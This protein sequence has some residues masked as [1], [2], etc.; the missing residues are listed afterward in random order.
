MIVVLFFC[1]VLWCCG[2]V[3][4]WIVVCICGWIVMCLYSWCCDMFV[5]YLLL[6]GILDGVFFVVVVFFGIVMGLLM[7]LFGS[8]GGMLMGL[9]L[10]VVWVSWLLLDW[11]SD[12]EFMWW[13]VRCVGLLNWCCWFVWCVCLMGCVV[14]GWGFCWWLVV[15]LGWGC[16]VVL[17]VVLVVWWC[18]WF[19]VLCCVCWVCGSWW[20]L[21]VCVGRW[22]VWVLWCV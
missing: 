21:V 1:V 22:L 4:C 15:W 12:C 6:I 9:F 13:C 20:F 5:V 7:W 8:D 10:F 19:L 3:C 11:G 2:L 18:W 14:V 17:L 16:L